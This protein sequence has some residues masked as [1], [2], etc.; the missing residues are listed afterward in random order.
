MRA[1]RR[2]VDSWWC[3]ACAIS[4]RRRPRS[5]PLSA[6]ASARCA[7]GW[8]VSRGRRGGAQRPQPVPARPRRLP[9]ERVAEIEAL[10]RQRMSGPPSP[11]SSACPFH[12]RR[13]AA[14]AGP[15]PPQQ[16]R[17]ARPGRALRTPAPRR[18]HPHRHQEARPDRRH[19]PPHH[20][21]AQ[22]HGQPHR[23]IGWEHL[24]V[25]VD[26][27][28]RLAYTEILPD[29][30]KASAFGFLARALALFTPTASASSAS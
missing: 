25:A 30:R 8:P 21:P 22:R 13:R 4:S 3:V 16:P 15:R 27:A 14:P 7:S 17:S 18:A 19:R 11:A 20:R 6:S 24:H 28:S 5:P 1:R 9:A 26:D 12:R 10:R 2:M 29:E 23:G